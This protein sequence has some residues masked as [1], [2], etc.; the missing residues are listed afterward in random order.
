MATTAP[1][2]YYLHIRPL[3]QHH[4]PRSGAVYLVLLLPD[5]PLAHL[6]PLGTQGNLSKSSTRL[7]HS[8]CSESFASFLEQLG[9]KSI[10]ST[11]AYRLYLI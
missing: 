4:H 1:T 3:N 5:L 8:L 2:S 9:K 6:Y 7:H 10:A 11:V